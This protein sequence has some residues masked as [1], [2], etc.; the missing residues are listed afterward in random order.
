[1]DIRILQSYHLPRP[2]GK[3][4]TKCVATQ[5]WLA[6][7]VVPQRI[8]VF[9][10]E[11][12]RE[13]WRFP[14]D[15]IEISQDGLYSETTSGSAVSF[16]VLTA[17][18]SIWRIP[19]V[20]RQKRNYEADSQDP[21]PLRQ[22]RR[23]SETNNNKSLLQT[24][25][26]S[27]ASIFGPARNI[28]T[29]TVA[30]YNSLFSP[31]T[32]IT[33]T[34]VHKILQQAR[35]CSLRPYN[36][37][38][39]NGMLI[40]SED[41]EIGFLSLVNRIPSNQVLFRQDTQNTENDL[42]DIFL[43]TSNNYSAQ[44]TK[45]IDDKGNIV[46]FDIKNYI[47]NKYFPPSYY[48]RLKEE[49]LLTGYSNGLVLF[50][51]LITDAP[52]PC[53]VTSLNESIQAIYTLS[54]KRK[55]TNESELSI[56][57][58]LIEEK[59]DNAF[60]FVGFKGTIALMCMAPLKNDSDVKSIAYKEYY[61]PAPVHSSFAFKN[62]LIVAVEDGN[63][64][65]INFDRD[66]FSEGKLVSLHTIPIYLPKGIIVLSYHC[67]VGQDSSDGVLYALS[68]DGRLIRSSFKTTSEDKPTYM[69]SNEEL[70][71]EIKKQLNNIAELTAKQT[72]LEKTNQ[73][74]NSAI[75]ARN[76]VIP[77]LQRFYKRRDKAKDKNP[78]LEV[79]CYPITM[80]TS[81]NGIMINMMNHYNS[82]KPTD[83]SPVMSYS[84][85]L[86]DMITVWERDI[87]I[88]LR[89]L[90]FPI[91]IKLGLCFSPP[92]PIDS[93]NAEH[94]KSKATH[95]PLV[96]IQYDILD[97]IKP[98]PEN[99]L[100][101]MQQERHFSIYPPLP[102]FIVPL[103]GD[104]FAT[105]FDFKKTLET[106]INVSGSD[107]E[108]EENP[109]TNFISSLNINTTII[110]FFLRISSNA[111]TSTTNQSEINNE[112]SIDD[113]WKRCLSVLLGENIEMSDLKEIIKT[114]DHAIF[115]TPLGLE[116][117]IL[118]LKKLDGCEIS[119]VIPQNSI[120]VELKITANSP[121]TLLFVEEALLG[122]LDDFSVIDTISAAS[123]AN[124]MDID[125]T[126]RT[127]M[128]QTIKEKLI[129]L[130]TDRDSLIRLREQHENVENG[131][132]WDNFV[133][134]AKKI[135]T[136]IIEIVNSFRTEMNNI[137]LNGV[138]EL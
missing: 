104:F 22:I 62:R 94:K 137:W 10:K 30:E 86:V 138:V 52:P 13:I 112:T 117:V 43:D 133:E 80:T 64:V 109:I 105:K 136:R 130:K 72:T 124:M 135:E 3:P 53:A 8:H 38:N 66:M 54:I 83:S 74:L 92:M 17:D 56:L 6:V 7:K 50:Q 115:I 49:I 1:M 26:A 82:S 90:H 68:S 116:P 89:F 96:N 31:P 103:E 24:S 42:S 111:S 14:A 99:I 58:P 102:N 131:V 85:S 122:R 69:M 84:V 34:D 46:I 29:T 88:N 36:L 39:R 23:I 57:R 128:S 91:L 71:E 59:V 120:G 118:N 63:I 25:Q 107:K 60:L 100:Q 28:A 97:F 73:L 35:I 119:N 132:A 19:L 98:C 44:L 45:V 114:A 41:G 51:P 5:D 121:E 101:R 76:L 81:L 2:L 110:K 126:A 4:I 12:L 65:V 9:F 67:I 21:T 70:R 75:A 108:R 79:E 18:G 27:Q 20:Q 127:L 77:E 123:S 87:E 55:V 37:F 11:A 106:L 129:N 125:E 93:T 48:Y 15:P 61:V 134:T 113:A 78:P 40:I 33:V 32:L 95:F 16:L 47:E